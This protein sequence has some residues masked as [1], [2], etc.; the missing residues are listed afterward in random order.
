MPEYY[1]GLISGTS[2]DAIDAA[3]VDISNNTPKLVDTL[4]YPIPP[5]LLDKLQSLI[6]PGDNEIHTMMQA[7]VALGRE[8]SRAVNQLLKQASLTASQIQAI[9]SHGQTLRHYPDTEAPNT[10]QIGDPNNIAELTGITT[11]ADFRRRDMA[12]GGQGAPL[13]PAFHQQV[14]SVD[15]TNTVVLNMGGIANITVLPGK[16]NSTDQGL[17]V[18]GYDTGP[19]NCLMDNWIQQQLG[20]PYDEAG[21]W[22]TSGQVQNDLL[23]T[24]LADPYLKQSAPKSTGREYYNLDW[25][26]HRLKDH[27]NQKPVDVQATL[28]EF[29]AVSIQQAIQT[30]PITIQRILVCGGGVYNRHL[31]G[32]IQALLPDIKI[33]STTTAGIEPDWVEAIAFAW[34]AQQ[35]LQGKTGNL[36]A[37]TGARHTVILGGIY[38][39]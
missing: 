7:D 21:K 4:S 37:V 10:L 16:Q 29:T 25:L 30:L 28:C 15:D 19:G 6:T 26:Q 17:P 39:I 34:L 24:L 9:G 36:P 18:S 22:A 12:A 33:S 38:R 2:M 35:T 27:H 23:N 14:F 1:I 5:V 8:F 31:L 3:L 11:V 20:K 13:V 32:R